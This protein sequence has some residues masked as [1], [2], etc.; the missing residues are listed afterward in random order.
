MPKPIATRISTGTCLCY[1]GCCH[2]AL[3]Q[4]IYTL[5]ITYTR[6]NKDGVIL[7]HQGGNKGRDQSKSSGKPNAFMDLEKKTL[8]RH[9]HLSPQKSD[10][11]PLSKL[12]MLVY[13][14]KIWDGF[15]TLVSKGYLWSFSTHTPR[16]CPGQGSHFSL[17]VPYANEHSHSYVKKTVVMGWCITH[18]IWRFLEKSDFKNWWMESSILR[19]E[20]FLDWWWDLHWHIKAAFNC[21][22]A[23][24]SSFAYLMLLY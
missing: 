1:S 11:S 21:W 7:C 5:C 22:L 8:R 20:L 6:I 15:P 17:W 23:P 16:L 10:Y 9:E 4:Y 3:S 24:P 14:G 19:I 13:I 18:N 2:S 12:R